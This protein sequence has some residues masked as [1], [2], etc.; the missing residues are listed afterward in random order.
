MPIPYDDVEYFDHR[1]SGAGHTA[2]DMALLRRVEDLES[3]GG[4]GTVDL[5][6]IQSQLDAQA[7]VDAA[8]EAVDVAN[9]AV[10]DAQTLAINNKED[11][12]VAA[13]LDALIKAQADAADALNTAQQTQ[14]DAADTLAAAQQLEIDAAEAVNTAQQAQID[15][16]DMSG[17]EDAGVAATLDA[18]LQAQITAA[19]TAATALQAEIDA[20]EA[21]NVAQQAQL[22]AADTLNTAQTAAIN[23]KEDAGVAA[24]LDA[25]LQMQ[26]TANDA[27]DV[28]Q[29]TAIAANV[30]AIAALQA[31]IV[32]PDWN[33]AETDDAGILNKPDISAA[34]VD[35]V[36]D[37][38][39]ADKT[40]STQG[41]LLIEGGGEVVLSDTPVGVFQIL[42]PANQIWSATNSPII[43]TGAPVL[44]QPLEFL[45]GIVSV[46]GDGTNWH[47]AT[48]DVCCDNTPVTYLL[49]LMNSQVANGETLS[50]TRYLATGDTTVDWGDGSALET[51]ASGIQIN[52]VSHTFS[53][54]TGNDVVI[55]LMAAGIEVTQFAVSGPWSFNTENLNM[56]PIT[57]LQLPNTYVTG[58]FADTPNLTFMLVTGDNNVFSGSVTDAPSIN[59]LTFSGD[60]HTLD[61]M[62]TSDLVLVDRLNLD[63]VFPLSGDG[64]DLKASMTNCS[65]MGAGQTVSFTTATLRGNTICTIDGGC[66]VTGNVEDIVS[67][68]KNPKLQ[69]AGV[70]VGGNMGALHAD[71]LSFTVTS[72]NHALNMFSGSFPVG[73]KTVVVASGA[74]G[75]FPA[76]AIDDM[77]ISLAAN[78]VQGGTF[79]LG[80]EN[81]GVRTSASDAAYTTLTTSVAASG[82]GWSVFNV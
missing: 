19:N 38:A 73:M 81:V 9:K 27:L 65:I 70:V 74:M 68:I 46:W 17:K 57:W 48:S 56:N 2:R 79:S 67:T 60:N 72:P 7:A 51:I 52:P 15:A 42:P 6:A 61:A 41:F 77:L 3:G 39:T 40:S 47:V 36:S 30:T 14:L 75:A 5:T 49:N 10:D 64:S 25:A 12:G 63:G 43:T 45:G 59:N 31:L 4:G 18:A 44:G 11:A 35:Y 34:N 8:Q 33:A 23:N 50:I 1:A 37:G 62:T 32:K 24:T 82:L 28:A 53:S 69:G 76:A 22:D 21:V 16:I 58:D 54:V 80:N 29:Q 55:D 78:G 20:A 71:M 66:T 13:T 26:I